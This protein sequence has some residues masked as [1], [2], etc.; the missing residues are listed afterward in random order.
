MT[1]FRWGLVGG[2][3]GSQIGP[4]HRLGATVDG[5]FEFVAGALDAN[6][7]EGRKFSLELGLNKNRA[8]GDWKEMLTHEINQTDKLDLVTVATPNSTHFEISKAFLEA[9]FNILCE[10]PM[11][12]NIEE[13]SLTVYC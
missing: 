9:G 8:Y 3:R 5:N 1:K 12:M 4:A 6:A 7:D 2:G 10:K 13:G 11:T